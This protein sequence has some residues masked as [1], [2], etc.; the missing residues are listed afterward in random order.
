MRPS[1][2][3][4]ILSALPDLEAKKGGIFITLII[5]GTFLSLILLLIVQGLELARYFSISS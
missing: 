2:R 5:L 4:A 1:L 3:K